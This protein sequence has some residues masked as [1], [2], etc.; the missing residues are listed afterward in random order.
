LVFDRT[1]VGHLAGHG[2]G[3]WELV[4][5]KVSLHGLASHHHSLAEALQ[6]TRADA[7]LDR[8]VTTIRPESPIEE[9]VRLIAA[10]GYRY[11]PVVDGEGR[12]A[13]L[14]GRTDLLTAEV[15]GG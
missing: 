14:V 10:T 3:L 6:E 1:L 4:T 12:L 15:A 7:L 5:G 13:G 11:L 9:A 2:R 8:E